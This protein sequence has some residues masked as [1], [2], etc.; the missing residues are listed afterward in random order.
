MRNKE[1]SSVGEIGMH[2]VELLSKYH[3]EPRSILDLR[4]LISF[5]E[6][7]NYNWTSVT[8]DWKW[9]EPIQT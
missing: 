1:T 6:K 5:I 7:D 8:K 2:G 4:D 9:I 3:V